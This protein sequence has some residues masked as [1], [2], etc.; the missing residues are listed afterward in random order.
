MER[1]VA[2][3]MPSIGVTSELGHRR[4]VHFLVSGDVQGV[5]FRAFTLDRARGLRVSGWVRNCHDGKVEGEAEGTPAAIV[6]FIDLIERGPIS[7]H[8]DSIGVFDLPAISDDS[9]FRIT[10]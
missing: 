10:R 5:G 7:A 2:T 4:R 8:V 3:S 6:E 1:K 9:A